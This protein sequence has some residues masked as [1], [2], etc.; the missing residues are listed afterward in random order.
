MEVQVGELSPRAEIVGRLHNNQ[1]F[2]SGL[3]VLLMVLMIH[4][5]F[6]KLK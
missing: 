6:V 4:L 1:M 5:C 3:I 2:F